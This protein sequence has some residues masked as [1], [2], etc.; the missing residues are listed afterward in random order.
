MDNVATQRRLIRQVLSEWARIVSA[1]AIP[2]T[3]SV[4]AFDDERGQY[5][6]LQVGWEGQRRVHSVTVHARLIGG[7]IQIE[8]DWT[9]DGLATALAQRGIPWEAMT[10]GFH[11]PLLAA[12]TPSAQ[13]ELHARAE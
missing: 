10:F 2:D 1:Q 13:R 12:Q 5:L 7:K 4:V 8:Q 9:E 3:E 11:E 6:W